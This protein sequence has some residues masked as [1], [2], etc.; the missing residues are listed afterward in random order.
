MKLLLVWIISSAALITV[1]YLLPGVSVQ[2]FSAAFIAAL[3]LGLVNTFIRPIMILITLPATF[4]TL[5]MF[6]FVINGLLFWFVGTH[7]DGF[8]VEGFWVG[9]IGAIVYSI[10]TWGLSAAL[11]PKRGTKN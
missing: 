7:V 4:L 6:I 1:A 5:G 2:S 11:L 8:T 3:V 9:V 10:I